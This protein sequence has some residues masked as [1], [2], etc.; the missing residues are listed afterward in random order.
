MSKYKSFMKRVKNPSDSLFV[1]H[2]SCQSL[3]DDN[4][5][6]SPR[7]TSIAVSRFSNDQTVSFSIHSIAEELG[8]ERADVF[9]NIDEIEKKL[10]GRFNEFIK[11]RRGYTWVH[12]NM[13]NSTYGFEHIEHRYRVLHHSDMVNIP[14][15]NRENLNDV[16]VDRF[17]SGYAADPK[18]KSLMELNDKTHKVHRDF[19][20]GLEEVDA[21]KASEF[22]KV[23]KSTLCKV[24]FFAKV[25]TRLEK[26][27]LKTSSKGIGVMVDRIL[28]S[29]HSK[30]IALI[31][32]VISLPVALY[33]GYVWFN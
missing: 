20:T 26:G 1:I 32:G 31:A 16:L 25:I 33:Q 8:F 9:T 5:G 24:G 3:N 30:V 22:I 6:L 4:E 29:R 15:E 18:M 21:F 14:V 23:H 27:G 17:G 11:E 10:L 7:I 28:E 12:W 13:R 19:L 2:Y